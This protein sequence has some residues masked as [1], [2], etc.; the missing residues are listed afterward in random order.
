MTDGN[1]SLPD[2]Q[3]DDRMELTTLA[4][5]RALA[6]PL[7]DSILDLLLERAATVSELAA[8]LE[9]P[10]GTVAYHVKVLREAGLV[11][12]VRSRRV[13]AVE[14]RYYGRTARIQ[15]VG[16]LKAFDQSGESICGNYLTKAAR[17]SAPAHAVDDL[18]AIMRYTSISR[19][20]LRA[21]R[22]RMFALADEFNQL[23]R[24]GRQTYAFV[25]A[26]YPTEHRR[27]PEPSQIGD[28]DGGDGQSRG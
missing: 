21:F 26:V 13:R 16:A 8:A 19:E 18:S 25:A 23:P 2:Y 22:L 28:T 12:V 7:R 4:Q 9:R 15:Y 24:Q 3:L 11:K 10:K 27:L 17:E 1:T 14:E 5:V 6:G 20:H